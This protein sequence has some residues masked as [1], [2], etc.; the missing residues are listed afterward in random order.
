MT[1]TN[2]KILQRLQSACQ[3]TADE[4]TVAAIETTA[5]GFVAVFDRA[6][7][8]TLEV[9]LEV[10]AKRLLPQG[11]ELSTRLHDGDGFWTLEARGLGGLATLEREAL[12][13]AIVD[14]V[15]AAQPRGGAR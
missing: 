14:A 9:S 15:F 11:G 1:P 3:P 12:A 5:D 7:S 8:A 13:E 4:E 10:L 2:Q 6:V